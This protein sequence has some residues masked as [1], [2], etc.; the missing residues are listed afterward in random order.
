[1]E[2]KDNNPFRAALPPMMSKEEF[3]KAF[4]TRPNLELGDGNDI[5]LEIQKI[6][7]DFML[8]LSRHY[9]FYER[10]VGNMFES[11]RKRTPESLIEKIN[12]L[13]TVAKE[14]VLTACNDHARKMRCILV[15][16]LTGIA[17]TGKT[18]MINFLM[19][20]FPKAIFHPG[21]GI[22]QVPILKIHTPPRASRID[23]C[24]A[25]L[26]ELDD[27]LNGCYARGA[28]KYRENPL[29]DY[30]KGILALHFVGCIIFD[31]FQDL[32]VTKN[33]PAEQ[34]LA[35]VK[36]LT[37]ALGVP[38]VFVGSP[39]IKDVVFGNF[40]LATRSQ[41]YT[42][43]RL[44][45]EERD[46]DRFIDSLL[47]LNVFNQIEFNLEL[48]NLYYEIMQGIPRLTV[49]LHVEAQRIAVHE[50]SCTIEARHLLIAAMSVF[51]SV[52]EPILGIKK[53]FKNI[54]DRYP[55]LG[56]IE[57][58]PFQLKINKPTSETNAS[59]GEE[60]VKTTGT[61]PPAAG[62]P[63]I[64]IDISQY[65]EMSL[66]RYVENCQSVNEVHN[67]FV[68]NKLILPIYEILKFSRDDQY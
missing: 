22:T 68:E 5:R 32:K 54:L 39:E 18:S 49:K 66:F 60:K 21:L 43:E 65:Q 16:Y 46:W 4:N 27:V 33:G 48:K 64:K 19:N 62:P 25:I 29:G 26:C 44:D 24:K 20:Q 2:K 52:A 45:R 30:V 28:S 51:E 61:Q 56:K 36:R 40:Q 53:N 41:G 55:D 7:S 37:N 17:G 50:N 58:F 42:W 67:M 31:E 57:I 1:M 63:K 14:E 47:K 15:T 12:E 10:V 23:L 38:I 9:Y 8:G 6:E 59:S 35:F 3:F 13:R 11:Y 34:T